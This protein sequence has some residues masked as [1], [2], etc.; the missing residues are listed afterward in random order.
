MTDKFSPYLLQKPRT[1]EALA[2]LRENS[3]THL[4][5]KLGYSSDTAFTCDTCSD[6]PICKLAFD[7]YNTDGDCLLL[8]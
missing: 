2:V 7:C 4:T 8:K 1:G 5:Q 6:A 3:L